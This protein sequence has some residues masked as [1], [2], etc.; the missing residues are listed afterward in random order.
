MSHNKITVQGQNPDSSG[1]VSL[2]SLDIGDLNNV[3]I[4]TP[5]ADQVIKYDGAGYVNGAAPA[6]DMEYILIGQGESAAYSTSGASSLAANAS[7][8]FYDTNPINTIAGA[9]LSNSTGDWYDAITLPVG[10]YWILT[11]TRVEF[12]ASGYLVAQWKYSTSFK[13]SALVIGDN[14]NSYAGGAST[15]ISSFTSITGANQPLDFKVIQNSNVD[16]VAN[17]GNTI[18]EFTS[19]LIIKV[20][21]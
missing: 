5:S 17:Q 18:A 21:T 14:A 1:N 3:T 2:A 13:S 19:C 10:K 11:Q 9:T 16:S 7:I 6:G 4:T 12:S 15:T 8:E 20:T